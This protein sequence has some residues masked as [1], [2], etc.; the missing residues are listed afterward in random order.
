MAANDQ[1][2]LLL[3]EDVPQ[4]AQYIRG[5]L[6][7][8]ATIKLLDVVT[9]GGKAQADPSAAAR[10]RDRRRPPSG[11]AQGWPSSSQSAREGQVPVI[12][13]TVPQ[14]PVEADPAK[15]IHGVLT[16]PFSGYDLINRVSR[17]QRVPASA[18]TARAGCQRL[19]PEGRGG[20]DDDRLQPGR[21]DR[22]AGPRTVLID[23]SLQFGDLRALLKVPSTR[24]RSSTC[25]PTASPESDLRDVFWRD[26]SGIDILLAPPRVEMAEM[27]SVRDVEKVL[28]LLR[29]V[30][31]VDRHRHA[32]PCGISTSPFSTPPTLILEIITYDSTTLHNTLAVAD[33]FRTI[34]YSPRRFTT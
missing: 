10:R 9:D 7:S 8:Q 6:K 27:V 29:R 32:A 16:M 23:G 4:V 25:P 13:L 14:Q 17:P 19:R 30:Y 5:L 11:S 2:R 26:P 31:E 12:I 34:G 22:P 21:G 18:R 33:T 3:V 24:P 20:Q 1:I 15:G 28:S